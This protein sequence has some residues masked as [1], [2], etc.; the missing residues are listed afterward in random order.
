MHFLGRV[1]SFVS[2]FEKSMDAEFSQRTTPA[3]PERKDGPAMR[4]ANLSE[5][6]PPNAPPSLEEEEH[7]EDHQRA[8]DLRAK[9]R[10]LEARLE[11]QNDEFGSLQRVTEAMGPGAASLIREFDSRSEKLT[12]QLASHV[13]A[14]NQ[15]LQAIEAL[16]GFAEKVPEIQS[17][18]SQFQMELHQ[19]QDELQNSRSSFKLLTEEES[20]LMADQAQSATEIE[21]IQKRIDQAGQE[22][23]ELEKQKQVL[24]ASIDEG[25]IQVEQLS[26]ESSEVESDLQAANQEKAELEEKVAQLQARLTDLKQKLNAADEENERAAEERRRLKAEAMKNLSDRLIAEKLNERKQ[27]AEQ[28]QLLIASNAERQEQNDQKLRE[29]ALLISQTEFEANELAARVANG[30][31]A[32][33]KSVDDVKSQADAMKHRYET[34]VAIAETATQRL[35]RVVADIDMKREALRVKI[36]ELKSNC[37]LMNR[38]RLA[39]KDEFQSSIRLERQLQNELQRLSESIPKKR[40]RSAQKGAELAPIQCE[41]D[42]L[43]GQ[44]ATVLGKLKGLTLTS[45]RQI[46]ELEAR[47]DELQAKQGRASGQRCMFARWKELTRVCGQL[48][49]EAESKRSA[50]EKQTALDRVFEQTLEVVADKQEEL[51]SLKRTVHREKDFFRQQVAALMTESVPISP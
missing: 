26:K 40:E 47:L 37:E 30:P 7:V 48:E 6:E 36:D 14:E 24:N 44:L 2:D 11:D 17:E 23:I 32:I 3:E 8:D 15:A 34:T 21:Q 20:Q 41:V 42:R 4:A 18:L 10:D 39:V 50:I 31:S 27:L 5:D 19:L 28:H 9:I 22:I 13:A 33:Q 51:D 1:L 45:Q 25:L 29:L 49:R 38:K 12:S 35:A 16:S 46:S 43:E